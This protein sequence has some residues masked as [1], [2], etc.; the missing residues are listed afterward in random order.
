MHRILLLNF[1]LT[2][3]IKKCRS[4]GSIIALIPGT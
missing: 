2:V 1:K 3:S 4:C